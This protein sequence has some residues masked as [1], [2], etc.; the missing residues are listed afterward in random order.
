MKIDM[1]EK[2]INNRLKAVSQLR[3]LC[4]SLA[5]TSMGR[6]IITRFPEN[7]TVKRTGEA[8]GYGHHFGNQK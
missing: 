6:Q 5:D 4:L 8:L 3:K 7:E 2:A 1:S